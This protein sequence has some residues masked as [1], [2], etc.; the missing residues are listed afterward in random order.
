MCTVVEPASFNE[1]YETY[2]PFIWQGLR[3]LG[4]AAADVED[5]C[6]EV[7]IVVHRKLGSFEHRSSVRTWLYGIALRCASEY[8]RRGVR[9]EVPA[10]E[11]EQPRTA[12]SQMEALELRQARALLD[13]VLDTLDEDKRSV[14][15]LYELEELPMTE[16]A[17]IC[18]C[19]LQTAYS[20]LHAAR[21]KV[22]QAVQR[23]QAKEMVR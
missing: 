14:F 7:F 12:A 17:S 16:V 10:S 20:R 22:D 11:L 21:Q 15:V 18:E 4:V 1:V 2:A 23:L 3:R 9:R 5:V 19:P 13:A 6:Q 8:R